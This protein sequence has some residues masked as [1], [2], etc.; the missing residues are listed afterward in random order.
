M[1]PHRC[2]KCG[3][4]DPDLPLMSQC[5]NCREWF[6]DAIYPAMVDITLKAVRPGSHEIRAPY[7]VPP[8]KLMLSVHEPVD[9]PVPMNY[10][11]Y[12]RHRINTPVGPRVLFI[13]AEDMPILEGILSLTSEHLELIAKAA[14]KQTRDAIVKEL[15]SWN[16]GVYANYGEKEEAWRNGTL[17]SAASHL[18]A[19]DFIDY[20]PASYD[21]HALSNSRR[22]KT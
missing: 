6:P 4:Y 9:Q 17:Q 19:M 15:R 1:G 11:T 2:P 22:Q 16:G 21:P 7:Y 8:A 12:R 3:R 18:E 10:V 5:P 20:Y 14:A 13:R